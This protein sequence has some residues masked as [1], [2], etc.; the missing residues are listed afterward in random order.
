MSLYSSPD[1]SLLERTEILPLRTT[2]GVL[3]KNTLKLFV[4]EDLVKFQ[5]F[6][7]LW[8]W[9]GNISWG[10]IFLATLRSPQI[11]HHLGFPIYLQDLFISL[12]CWQH[13][14][15]GVEF[16]LLGALDFEMSSNL[17]P[18]QAL[19]SPLATDVSILGNSARCTLPIKDGLIYTTVCGIKGHILNG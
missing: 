9:A 3:S 2:F 18:I 15:K 14:A 16:L 6:L 8:S 19:S 17:S 13:W 11:P 1:K 4:K 7:Y 12:S 10:F 5:S